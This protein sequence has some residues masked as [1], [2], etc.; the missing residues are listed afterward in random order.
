M[1]RLKV[2]HIVRDGQF[3][4]IRKAVAGTGIDLNITG[5]DKYLAWTI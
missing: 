4:H 1:Q 2:L 5:R 3:T